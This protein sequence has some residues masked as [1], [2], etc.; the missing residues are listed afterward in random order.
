MTSCSFGIS[1]Q[2]HWTL[3]TR[4]FLV[5]LVCITTQILTPEIFPVLFCTIEKRRLFSWSSRSTFFVVLWLSRIC[6]HFALTSGKFDVQWCFYWFIPTLSV[7][8]CFAFYHFKDVM[9]WCRGFGLH[10]RQCTEVCKPH[11]AGLHNLE[12]CLLMPF[13]RLV[14][15]SLWL[16]SWAIYKTRVVNMLANPGFLCCHWACFETLLAASCLYAWSV[17]K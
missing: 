13:G 4:T 12:L 5:S 17:I 15:H 10:R 7:G 11:F 3:K 2:F 16:V 8:T 1:R 14:I 9:G 6:L